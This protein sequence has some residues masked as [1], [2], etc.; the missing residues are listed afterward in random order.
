MYYSEQL[1]NKLI[2]QSSSTMKFEVYFIFVVFS[3]IQPQLFFFLLHAYVWIFTI[4][5]IIQ[6]EI[7]RDL[8]L[9]SKF[10]TQ[11]VQIFENN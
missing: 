11:M 3:L 2:V 6:D 4:L 9:K 8:Q 5:I 10:V 7:Y 1:K